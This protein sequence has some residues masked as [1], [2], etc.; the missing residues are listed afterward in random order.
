MTDTGLSPQIR[1]LPGGDQR[2]LAAIGVVDPTSLE[3]YRKAGGYAGLARAI[4]KLGPEGTIDEIAAAGLR[5][6]GG[7]GYP[8]ADKWRA[9][10]GAAGEGKVV[11]ANLIG[12][13]PTALGDRA[14]AE[15]NPHLLLEGVLIAAFATGASD[16]VIAVRR[17]WTVAIERLRAAVA[18]AEAAHLA[19]YLVKGTD[20]SCVMRV[21]EGAA[22]LIA[23]E[24]T[25]LMAALEG[26]RGMPVI[27]P[28]YPTERGLGGAPTVV[29]N[30]ETLA[31]VAW[32]AAHGA[33]KFR[34][35][36]SKDA[37][38]TKLVSV[39][40]RVAQ[41]G[42]VEVALGTPLSEIVAFAGGGTGTTK[43]AFVGGPG[44]GAL[45]ADQ[46]DTPYD[47]A[48]LHAAGA[49]ISLGQ[50]LVADTHTCMVDSARFFLDYSA[51]EACG[52]AVPCR[53]GTKRLVE[54]LDR[55]LAAS[56]RPNDLLLLREL[57]R[58]MSDTALCHLEA[59]A[60][61][62]MLTTLDRFP[63]E[64]RAHAERGE[65]LAGAC[66]TSPQPPLLV[67]LAGL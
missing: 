25:A 59:R 5:G 49:G 48:P 23:G 17:D 62:P 32:I 60:P 51:R 42:L 63:D 30:G 35:I 67:P 9:A 11:V 20:F 19:G 56:P 44:G 21:S 57:S 39:Y 10:R 50:F 4:E 65:C 66:R 41:P 1:I 33:K 64:Y 28:P 13:D 54:T 61:G 12:A 37:P 16:A 15:G 53:I 55:I 38:G 29:Q 34:A 26:D 6:R 46:F 7:G 18:E 22:A 24:E 27:R 8:T 2:L 36:G 40:G 45:R 47:Y 31:H 3:G 14:L 52:K 58:K 43:A